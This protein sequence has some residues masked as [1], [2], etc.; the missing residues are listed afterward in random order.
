VDRPVLHRDVLRGIQDALAGRRQMGMPEGW[1]TTYPRLVDSPYPEV[2]DRAL[3]LAVLFGD[4]RAV[5]ALRRLAEDTRTATAARENALQT[6]IYRGNSDLVPLLQGLLRDSAL[7]GAALRG[8]AAFT[9]ETT[10]QAILH[11]YQSFSDEDRSNA[12]QTL[13]S[14][15]AYALALLEAIEHGKVSRRDLSAFTVRQMLGL[16]NKAVT[17]KL[18]KVWGTVRPASQQKA[19]LM[20]K[21]K[22]LLTPDYLKSANR[23]H[24]RL[25]FK[26]TC[27]ACHRLFDDGASIGPELTGSQRANL[28]YLLENV[29]DPSAVVPNEYQ[30]IVLATTNGRVLSG[31]IKQE[32]DRTVTVQTQNESVIVPKDEIESREKSPVS[33]M[34][35]GLLDKLTREEVRDLI[36]YVAGSSQVALPGKP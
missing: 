4:E 33:M 13:A 21:Y 30:V 5:A 19:A 25:V 35:E 20:K 7:R 8:L 10:P 16:K 29:L 3:A 15:P 34:P 36:A 17:E 26:Q 28:D 9:D 22:T 12:I 27:A 18:A 14:R 2:R 24:G 23:S 6:L 32:S 11:H 31:I 1:R